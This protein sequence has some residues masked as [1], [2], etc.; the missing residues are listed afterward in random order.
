MTLFFNSTAPK[1]LE[2][3]WE[4]TQLGIRVEGEANYTYVDLRG[5]QGIQGATGA[6]GATGPQGLKGDKGDKGDQGIQGLQGPQGIQGPPVGVLIEPTPLATEP[7]P[8]SAYYYFTANTTEGYPVDALLVSSLHQSS[9]R[10]TQ[11]AINR[12]G[13]QAFF[14]AAISGAWQPWSEIYNSRNLNIGT[15]NHIFTGNLFTGTVGEY[16]FSD[17]A[18]SRYCMTFNAYASSTASSGYRFRNAGFA[19][20]IDQRST[21]GDVWLNTS[22]ASGN[23][24]EA[25]TVRSLFSFQA[26][27][28]RLLFYQ[29]LNLSNLPT[30][31]TGLVAGDVWRDTNGFLRVV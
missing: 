26:S 27:T 9:S 29:R 25:I 24:G 20:W 8:V 6:T 13:N 12:T 19:F 11:F 10:S 23:P 7:A 22:S 30:S 28:N 31:A 4:G 14:R 5:E 15:L 21:N 2:F 16:R 17:S 1:S 3:D 18:F